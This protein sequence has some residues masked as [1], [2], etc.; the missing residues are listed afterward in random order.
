M[1]ESQSTLRLKTSTVAYLAGIEQV[2]LQGWLDRDNI[3]LE[4]IA[5]RPGKDKHRTYVFMDAIRIAIIGR[6]LA[7]G[8]T[9]AKTASGFVEKILGAI[10]S[11]RATVDALRKNDFSVLPRDTYPERDQEI[12]YHLLKS[13]LYVW[14]HEETHEWKFSLLQPDIGFL[15]TG[16]R[17]KAENA[18]TYI[19]IKIGEVV[20]TMLDRIEEILKDKESK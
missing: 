15:I 10:C 2:R 18:D 5:E 14:L 13:E 20:S 6:L 4:A 19:T 11:P 17:H 9:S 8:M 7:H 16:E 1:S 3:Y 12:I